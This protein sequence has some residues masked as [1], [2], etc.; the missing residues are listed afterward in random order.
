MKIRD[1]FESTAVLNLGS[2]KL[3]INKLL[4]TICDWNND[5][6]KE[7]ISF[8]IPSKVWTRM[9]DNKRYREPP[10]LNCYTKKNCDRVW[11]LLVKE[12]KSSKSVAGEFTNDSFKDSIS[13]KGYILVKDGLIIKVFSNSKLENDK[14]WRKES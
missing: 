3:S 7:N 12:G 5:N 8:E 13:L 10:H 14:I 6:F 4:K 9:P 2:G 1:I 11:E